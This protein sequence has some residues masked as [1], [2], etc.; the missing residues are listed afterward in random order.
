MKTRQRGVALLTVLLL[1]AVMSVLLMAVLDDIRFGLRRASNAQNMAQAQWYALG[2]EAL[3][4]SRIQALARSGN[5]R[6]TL[7]G[8]WNDRPFLFPLGEDGR[9]DGMLSARVADATACFNLNS[10]VE[11]A[12]EQWQRSEIGMI[13]YRALLQALEFAPQQAEALSDTLVDWLD[14]DQNP[15]PT[16][17]E[18]SAYAARGGLRTSGTLL[19]EVSELRAIEG[20]DADVFAR[21][22]P[23]V[24]A[25]PTADL[26]P[27]NINT[28]EDDDAVILSMLTDN[29][30]SLVEARRI[31]AT[32]PANGWS[33]IAFWSQPSLERAAVHDSVRQQVR[34]RSSYFSLH[35]EVEYAGAQVVMSALFEQDA[36]GETRLLVRRWS[37]DE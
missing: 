10:V 25:L 3:A 7:A 12:G 20:Y 19:A 31:L 22:R 35:S 23:H 32:R 4:Q 18:D 34:L 36:S 11:G 26:A 8:D 28:L 16:G 37:N 17:A 1:V 5:G 30:V 9:H 15:Q 13:Q 2:T 6:T 14:A 27:V 33:E 29:K 24:C 21:L